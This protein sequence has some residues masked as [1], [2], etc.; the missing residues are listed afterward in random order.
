MSMT[1][2]AV[3]AAMEREVGPFIKDW[4]TS[5][6]EYDGRTFK[7]FE[8]ESMVVVCGGIGAEGA[9]RA[10]EAVIALYQPGLVISAGFAG[11][12]DPGLQVGYTLNARHVI[13]AGDG[14]RTD[15]G[16]GEGILISFQTV[17]DAQQKAKFATAFGGHAVDMEAAA[18]AR[19]AEAHGVRFLACKAISDTSDAHLPRLEPFIGEDGKFR[20]GK[21][22]A[23]IAIRPW[24]WKGIRRLASDTMKAAQSLGLALEQHGR[25]WT[26]S[27]TQASAS[28]GAR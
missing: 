5:S 12:L 10:A 19:A 20:V 7:F 2:V 16:S 18:V 9:R 4:P 24:L 3:V 23:Y 21:F 28:R 14:S 15:S 13:D 27:G 8:K 25:E 22:V 17:A 6:K 11:A 1:R 26:L